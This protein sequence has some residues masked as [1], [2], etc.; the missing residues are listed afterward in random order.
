MI[1]EAHFLRP[2]LM[3]RILTT[4]FLIALAS[5]LFAAE[6]PVGKFLF[7]PMLIWGTSEVTHQGTGYLMKYEN[8]IFGVT[9]IHFLNFDAGGLFEAIWLD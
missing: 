5:G 9:S 1:H 2:R 8:K 4:T 3:R 6:K 7:Q